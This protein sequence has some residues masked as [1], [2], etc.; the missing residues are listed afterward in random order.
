VAKHI[1]QI[2]ALAAWLAASPMVAAQ[3][4]ARAIN[5]RA[6]EGSKPETIPEAWPASV[7]T[8]RL[9]DIG[10][11]KAVIFSPDFAEFGNRQFYEKLGFLYIEDASWQKALN[12]VIAR[13]YWHPEDRIESIFLETHGTN[14]NGLKLQ[15][16]VASGARRS[17]ISIGALLEKLEGLG[18]RLCVIGACNAGRLFRPEIYKTLNPRPGDRLFL[19]AT[20]G[21]VNASA[22][23]DPTSSKI[24]VVRR[25]ESEIE[26][27]SDGDT[28]ELSP[29]ARTILGLDK[30]ARGRE[31]PNLHFVV[32]NLLIQILL[33]DP[34]LK[35]TESGY[36]NA[37]SR[38]DLT[39]VESEVVFERF[40]SYIDEV[41][42]REYRTAHGGRLPATIRAPKRVGST[43]RPAG[44]NSR[45]AQA[46]SMRAKKRS[47]RRVID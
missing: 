1:L 12:Q 39:D 5:R 29:L 30:P 17:Y 38:R 28:S 3:E 8:N 22:H 34:R 47:S 37:K 11:G 24:I 18:V 40:L 7:P 6:V 35:L 2:T 25:A 16:G 19:P 23:Y 21:I 26:T 42:E 20:L 14:G 44:Y 41:A 13:N 15:A 45:K 9:P 4:N 36:T 31:S 32:S 43:P 10:R 46:A 27:T 33:H